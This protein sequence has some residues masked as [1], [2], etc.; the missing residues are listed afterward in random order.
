MTIPDYIIIL[1]YFAGLLLLGGILGK[2]IKKSEDMFIAGRNSSWWLS[3]LST[4]MT[5][6]SASTFV[7]WGGVAYKSGIV[8]VTIGMVL[9]VASIFVGRFLVGKWS[10]QEINSPAEYLGIR[11]DKSIVRFYTIIGIIGK[12]VHMAVGL[13]AIAIMA[14]ALIPLPENHF[15]VDSETGHMSVTYAVLFLG[16]ITFIYTAAGGFLAVLMTDVVQ[17]AVLFGMILIMVPLSFESVGGVDEFIANAP[18]GFFSLFSDQYSWGWMVLWLFLNFFMIGGDWAFVQRYISVPSVRDAKKSA[19][20]V[21][22]LYLVTPILWYTPTLVYRTINPDVNPE[23]SYMLMSQHILGVGMLGIMLAAMI[24][25]TLSTVSGTLNVFAN[26][27]AYDIFRTLRPKASDKTLITIGRLFTYVY[28]LIITIVAVM[29]PYFG[30]AERVVVSILTL[31][32]SP[33]FIPSIWGLFSRRIGSKAV[34]LSMGITYLLGFVIKAGF[35]DEIVSKQ[36]EFV[37]AFIGFV[38]PSTILVIMELFLWKKEKDKGWNR[39]IQ[40]SKQREVQDEKEKQKSKEAGSL[41]SSMAIK[42]MMGTYMAIGITMAILAFEDDNDRGRMLLFAS[43]FIGVS[44]I[45]LAI[46]YYKKSK[47][48]T[49]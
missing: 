8:A 17:F 34:W 32:I 14:V 15:L 2:R 11:F 48:K 43:I 10:M 29:I 40:I 42:I 26:V 35:F 25:A 31:V 27:F 38:V 4:Y 5:I 46:Y 18:E 23:Q 28:G 16:I 37:D 13:Y 22:I 20:L 9:G 6:F 21:G 12:G 7:V 30:G 47:L 36:V 3:G 41:Y 45:V 33:L 39:F 19:Y 1:I 44:T 49:N 24:S